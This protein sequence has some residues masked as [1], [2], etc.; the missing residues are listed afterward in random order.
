MLIAAYRWPE[1]QPAAEAYPFGIG[2][3]AA[4]GAELFEERGPVVE[5]ARAGGQLLRARFELGVERF[6]PS[7]ARGQIGF[8]LPAVLVET[9]YF[10]AAGFDLRFEAI[11]P[12]EAGFG[13]VL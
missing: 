11:Y 9:I 4:L 5:I 10:A 13:F 3:E 1:I 8:E 6:A 2:D 7:G 12:A